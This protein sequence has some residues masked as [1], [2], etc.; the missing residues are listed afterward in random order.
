LER[1]S[2]PIEMSLEQVLDDL[3]KGNAPP[4]YLLYGDEEYRLKGA[5]D[6]ILD[7]LL[8]SPERDLQLFVTEGED[9]DV[10]RVC[11]SLL[12]PSLFPGRKVLLIRDTRLLSSADTSSDRVHKIRD[13]AD[14]NPSR[15]AAE[16]LRLIRLAGWSPEDLAG[17]GRRIPEERWREVLGEDAAAAMR[18][19][20]PRVLAACEGLSG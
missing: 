1:R 5:L 20:L 16:F 9:E 17:G 14:Q 12:M 19:W 11:E 18:T 6:R 8:P 2:S 4:C 10:D 7:G 15:A 3:L 13:L